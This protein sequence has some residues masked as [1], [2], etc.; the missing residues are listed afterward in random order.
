[1]AME[2]T[3][4]ERDGSARLAEVIGRLPAAMQDMV[5][6]FAERM[7]VVAEDHAAAVTSLAAQADAL[8]GEIETSAVRNAEM[9]ETIGALGE[10]NQ[11]LEKEVC[12]LRDMNRALVGERR[13]FQVLEA[14]VARYTDRKRRVDALLLAAGA[15][16]HACGTSCAE[17]DW[18]TNTRAGVD[19]DASI[20]G[21]AE[22]ASAAPTVPTSA[23]GR[24]API[25]APGETGAPTAEAGGEASGRRIPGS[26]HVPS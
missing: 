3:K 26:P 19:A 15:D 13:A 12:S 11:A 2:M 23:A 10:R 24:G 4:S 16:A 21:D 7:R 9:A 25:R 14:A 1:M 18:A 17:P 5:L 6:E 8:R 22:G 20:G